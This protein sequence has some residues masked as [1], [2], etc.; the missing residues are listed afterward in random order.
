MIIIK[1][2]KDGMRI[3]KR[4]AR[5]DFQ[6]KK[7]SG[8]RRKAMPTACSR[9]NSLDEK[10]GGGVFHS[11]TFY[12]RFPAMF[13]HLNK[14]KPMDF[15][16]FVVLRRWQ[17]PVGRGLG[18]TTFVSAVFRFCNLFSFPVPISISIHFY[19]ARKILRSEMR[20]ACCCGEGAG[21]GD[22]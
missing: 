14:P 6:S 7:C 17:H 4:I 16:G 10:G 2:K 5:V 13:L 22:C 3:Q 21:L 8:Y 19:F 11:R 15:N 1:R 20:F 18:I 12:S 9:S